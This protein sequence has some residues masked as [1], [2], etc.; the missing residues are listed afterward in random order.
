MMFRLVVDH[1]EDVAEFVDD[2]KAD[3]G[4]ERL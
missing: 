2:F 3:L 1:G 4:L